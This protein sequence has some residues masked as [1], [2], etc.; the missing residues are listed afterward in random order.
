MGS[1]G[2]NQL[3]EV[4]PFRIWLPIPVP[5]VFPIKLAIS[6]GKDIKEEAKIIGITPAVFTF[7]GMELD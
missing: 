4:R 6:T 1:L 5:P 3:L 2:L 7:K